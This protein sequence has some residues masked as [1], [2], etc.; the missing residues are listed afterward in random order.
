MDKTN[1]I[2]E[3]EEKVNEKTKELQ[4]TITKLKSYTRALDENSIVSISDT[5]GKIKY[6]NDKFCEVTGFT[7]EELIGK[8]HSIIKH[9]DMS[10]E[11]FKDMW[12][13]ISN[14]KVWHGQIKNKKKDGTPYIVQSAIIPILN[15]EGEIEEYIATRYEITELY[16]KNKEISKLA[17]TDYLT[18]L[19]NRFKLNETIK[20]IQKASIALI[21][22]ND[23]HEINDF[24]GDKVGDEVI[25]QFAKLLEKQLDSTYDIFHLQGDEFVILNT[26]VSQND[27][28]IMM[29]TLNKFFTSKPIIDGEKQFYISTTI[30]LSFETA[31]LLVSTAHLAHTYA[32]ENGILYNIYSYETSPEKDYANNFNW[33]SKIKKAI[34]DDKIKVFFQPIVDTNT[35]EVFKYEAL[36]RLIDEEGKIISPYFFLDISK[37]ANYYNQI[38]KI[39]IKQSIEAV[40]ILNTPISINVTIEDITNKKTKEFLFEELENCPY[41]DKITFELVESES[42]ENF[43][44]VNQVIQHIKSFGC[45]LA[46]D[47]FGTGYSNFEYL[48]KLNA[49][50]IKID[51]SMIKDIDTNQDNYDIVKTIVSFAKIKNLQ[52]VAE[53]VSSES[54]YE[55]MK[56]LEIDYCQGYYF[57]AAEP[58]M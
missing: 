36:V 54:I 41:C 48:L 7:K 57:G 46:I 39:V 26:Q 52:V 40:K 53:F 58:L 45:S 47:D 51:G 24:Y 25:I 55:K 35:Q 49:D 28:K 15:S 5:K 33:L 50:I 16:E 30:S 34:K 6:V 27:F 9:E 17:R 12:K 22:I 38:A 8:P 13:T 29:K 32:K 11:V 43:E 4:H 42:I 14:K 2:K 20:S 44:E 23:F 18:G 21:D 3:L 37:K 31:N 19:G 1:Y 10:K 56:Q